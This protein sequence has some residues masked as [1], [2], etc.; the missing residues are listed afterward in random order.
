MENNE[1]IYTAVVYCDGS[2]GPSNPG[3]Y[4]S[5]VHGYLYTD[6]DIKEKLNDSPNGYVMCTKGYVKI[7]LA[8]NLPKVLPSYYINGMY[9]YPEIGTNNMAEARAISTT[10]KLLLESGYN[11]KKMIFKT[12]SNYAKGIFDKVSVE[13][14]LISEVHMK[15]NSD[16]WFDVIDLYKELVKNNIELEMIKVLGHSDVL[17]NIITDS[18]AN[19][20]RYSS[21]Q[22]NIGNFFKITPGNK[23]WKPNIKKEPFFNVKSLFFTHVDREINPYRYTIMNYTTSNEIGTNDNS[24]LFG[25]VYTK[26]QFEDIEY[27]LD[28][29]KKLCN[30]NYTLSEL[31]MSTYYSQEHNFYKE[32]FGDMIY[33]P[34]KKDTGYNIFDMPLTF[35]TFQG[36]AKVAFNRTLQLEESYLRYIAFI[37]KTKEVETEFIDITDLIYKVNEKGKRVCFLD[38]KEKFLEYTYKHEKKDVKVIISLGTEIMDR[39]TLKNIEKEIKHVYLE[40]IKKDKI[41]QTNIIIATEDVIGVYTNFFTRNIII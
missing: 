15:P 41:L 23:Y 11:I 4:G 14:Y 17:G 7:D 28:L 21:E 3:F 34:N 8:K 25:L 35:S 20:A 36:L 6:E 2:A 5:G 29:D 30:D 32:N 12:D 24:A 39:N 1:K 26:G 10:I 9:S 31:N 40:V 38:Q 13:D 33:V 27:I 37:N 22:K 16:I 19:V 18:L